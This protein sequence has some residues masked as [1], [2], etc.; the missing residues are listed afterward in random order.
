MGIDEFNHLSTVSYP[1]DS[2]YS[3]KI[4][5]CKYKRKEPLGGRSNGSLGIVDPRGLALHKSTARYEIVRSYEK[6]H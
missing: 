5:F 2:E 3:V 1:S 6:T 4:I